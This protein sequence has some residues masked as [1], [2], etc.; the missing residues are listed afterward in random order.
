MEILHYQS[1]CKYYRDHSEMAYS[2]VFIYGNE[3]SLLS[4]EMLLFAVID[5]ATHSRILSAAI[6][7]AISM[8]IRSVSKS[9][10]TNNLVK[11]SLVDHR[12]LI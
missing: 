7:Y 1:I 5:M 6:V 12:F 10:F 3:W 2:S 9:F 11:S 8:S 4:F